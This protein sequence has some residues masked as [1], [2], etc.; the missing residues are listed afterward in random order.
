MSQPITQVRETGLKARNRSIRRKRICDVAMKLLAAKGYDRTSLKDIADELGIRHPALYYYYRSKDEILLDAVSSTMNKLVSALRE[1]LEDLGDA[2]PD[3]C[4]RC[5]AERQVEFQL[6]VKG[7]I[8]LVDSV[9]FGPLS[10]AGIIDAEGRRTLVGVQRELTDLYRRQIE[11][12][13]REGVF[14]VES[15]AAATYTVLGAISYVVYWFRDDGPKTRDEIARIVA[16][17]CVAALNR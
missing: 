6:E 2:S 1:A 11:R 5:L 10:A 16:G 17:L 13:Q 14:R 9:L 7:L 8:P 12:G 4:L 15:I 3:D